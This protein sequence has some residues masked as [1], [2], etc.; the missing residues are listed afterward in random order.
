MKLPHYP[1]FPLLG[2][3]R[4][5]ENIVLHKD[6]YMNVSNITMLNSQNQE[7]VWMSINYWI[8]KQNLEYPYSNKK[9]LTTDNM[10]QTFGPQKHYAWLHKPGCIYIKFPEG[11][12]LWRWKAEIHGCVGLELGV[13][14]DYKL[15]PTG[16]L[17]LFLC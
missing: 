4:R 1:L 3:P 8:N 12:N 11:A 15:S 17:N 14:I 10:L 6:T 16:E 2:I 7:T 13:G 9:K 5:K